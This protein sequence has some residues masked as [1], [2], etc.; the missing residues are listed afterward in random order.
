[1]RTNERRYKILPVSIETV[2]SV[3]S[4][5]P[6]QRTWVILPDLP[7]DARVVDVHY[8]WPTGMFNYVIESEAYPPALE[9]AEME[10]L[11]VWTK[12]KRYSPNEMLDRYGAAIKE[13]LAE[14]GIET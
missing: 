2:L 6:M 13:I 9:G 3:L 4:L 11:G 14:M 8:H 1:M 10:W 5:S 12:V 7:E